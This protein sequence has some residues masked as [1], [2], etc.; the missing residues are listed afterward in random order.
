[1][2]FDVGKLDTENEWQD[3]DQALSGEVGLF[4]LRDGELRG[5]AVENISEGEMYFGPAEQISGEYITFSEDMVQRLNEAEDLDYNT[6]FLMGPD[7]KDDGGFYLKHSIGSPWEF[8]DNQNYDFE[9]KEQWHLHLSGWEVYRARNGSLVLGMAGPD[10]DYEQDPLQSAQ[11]NDGVVYAVADRDNAVFVPPNVP[12]R[13]IEERGD[14]DHIVTRYG[15]ETDR[16][17]KFHLDGT[18]FYTWD[19]TEDFEIQSMP[20]DTRMPFYQEKPSEEQV[21]KA[22]D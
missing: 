3:V 19:D 6:P 12:H 13:V 11:N 2:S 7:Q 21:V 1:M 22:S 4:A 8:K 15:P 20:S 14:P 5:G 9:E 17:P 18:P 10:F 16:V